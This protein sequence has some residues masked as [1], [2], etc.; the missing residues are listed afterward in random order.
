M[1]IYNL[2]KLFVSKLMATSSV[3]QD[4][5]NSCLLINQSACEFSENS[6]NLIVTIYNPLSHEAD[7]VI[8]LPVIKDVDYSVYDSNGKYF[9]IKF[10][11]FLL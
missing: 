1:T 6:K 9:T 2:Y 5:W 10:Y 7:R 8:R 3:T 11:L 4:S